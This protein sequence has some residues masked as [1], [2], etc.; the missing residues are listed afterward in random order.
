MEIGLCHS[1]KIECAKIV[2]VFCRKSWIKRPEDHGGRLSELHEIPDVSFQF[3]YI[4][5]YLESLDSFCFQQPT[6]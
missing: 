1:N 3:F 5:K 2:L 4:C 6:E